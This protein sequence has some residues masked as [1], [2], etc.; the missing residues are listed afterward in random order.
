[1]ARD[2][3]KK[4]P[5]KKKTKVAKARAAEPGPK[6]ATSKRAAAAGKKKPR[7]AKAIRSAK[8][9]ASKLKDNPVVTEVVAAALVATAAA[10]RDPKRARRLAQE[11]G[12]ELLRAGKKA[13]RD[14]KDFWKLA[15]DIARRTLDS[16]EGSDEA[17]PRRKKK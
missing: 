14:S 2:A 6:A 12:D 3:A 5:K 17:P 16:L 15:L 7:V 11:A 10:L 8:T 9:A 13:T 1:V 4:K